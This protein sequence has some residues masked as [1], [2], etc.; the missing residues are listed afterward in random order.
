MAFGWSGGTYL[1]CKNH[2]NDF[3]TN[4][5]IRL[6]SQEILIIVSSIII[7]DSGY[8]GYYNLVIPGELVN[9][10]FTIILLNFYNTL[11]LL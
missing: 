10:N 11:V 2:L 7:I 8:K 9:T 1:V 6:L 3:S 4:L 5:A